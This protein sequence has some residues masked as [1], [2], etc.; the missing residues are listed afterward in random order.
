MYIQEITNTMFEEFVKKNELKTIY[1]TQNY[2]VIM[3]EF[4]YDYEFIGYI[5]NGEIRAVSLILFKKLNG[6]YIGYAPRGFI[7]DYND[8]KLLKK[9]THALKE[10]Y[11]RK[12]FA[13]IKINPNVRIGLIDKNNQL[14]TNDNVKIKN[15]LEKN[16]YKKLKDNL[17][18]ESAL[19]RFNAIINLKQYKTSNLSKNT[20]N[21]IKKGLRKGL[22]IKKGDI[23]D[24]EYLNQ[25]VNAKSFYYNDLY[26]SFSKN[27]ETDIILVTIDNYKYLEYSQNFYIKESEKNQDLNELMVKRSHSKNIN[28]K[29]NS[30]LALLS[31]KKDIMEATKLS[32]ENKTHVIA[33]AL[34]VRYKDHVE[35][36]A[37]GYD[38]NFKR[39]VPNYFLH[40]NIIKYYKKEART[41]NISGITGDFSQNS[42]YDGLNRF[43]K[44]FNPVIEEF[45]GEYDLVI[46]EKKYIQLLKSNLVQREFSRKL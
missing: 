17:Y 18:F 19:P 42:K 37:S 24:I 13:F 46:N 35:I 16:Q 32:D 29:M 10:F 3:A 45:I 9:F 12:D 33:A 15:Y 5:E 28:K 2:A 8:E 31:Y 1:Q 34:V 39:F 21:K 26:N 44:G 25:F 38:E 11:N 22:V 4:G 20:R 43:K 27:Y 41:L 23:D 30:D 40:Y 6:T 36:I 14:V 7:I